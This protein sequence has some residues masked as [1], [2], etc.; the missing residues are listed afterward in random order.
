[1]TIYNLQRYF[2]YYINS[3]FCILILVYINAYN[4]VDITS[5]DINPA[6]NIIYENYHSKTYKIFCNFPKLN[7]LYRFFNRLYDVIQFI[8]SEIPSR[9]VNKETLS[10]LKNVFSISQHH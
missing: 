7:T 4:R 6:L 3:T 9:I 1:M 5:D 8:S 2:I 10:T